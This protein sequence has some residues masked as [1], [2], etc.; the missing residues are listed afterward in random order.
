MMNYVFSFKIHFWNIR[1][2]KGGQ[3]GFGTYFGGNKLDF[4]LISANSNC[5]S[6]ESH[7]LALGGYLALHQHSTREEHHEI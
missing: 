5:I 6:W 1:I 7:Q 2:R 4:L 3:V